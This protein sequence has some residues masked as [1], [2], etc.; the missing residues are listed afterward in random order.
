MTGAGAGLGAGTAA[1][2]LAW[3]VPSMKERPSK[4]TP[5]SICRLGV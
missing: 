3:T 5:L 4:I 2:G 1:T